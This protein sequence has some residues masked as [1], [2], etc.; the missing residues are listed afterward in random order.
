MSEKRI[1]A[2]LGFLLGLLSAV[3]IFVGALGIGGNQTVDL[4]LVVERLV[5]IVLAVVI[6]LGSLLIYRGESSSGG[7]V[8][9]VVGAR[10]SGEKPAPFRATRSRLPAARPFLTRLTIASSASLKM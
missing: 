9:L 6:L 7:L 2:L 1:L 5:E 8:N 10:A 4:A 3:L